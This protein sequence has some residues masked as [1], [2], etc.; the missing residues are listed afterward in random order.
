MSFNIGSQR[1]QKENEREK[2]KLFRKNY[3]IYCDFQ[4]KHFSPKRKFIDIWNIAHFIYIFFCYPKVYD[5]FMANIIVAM[6]QVFC[7]RY[8]R[9]QL[10]VIAKWFPSQV[11]LLILSLSLSF[12]VSR[13]DHNF[14][15]FNSIIYALFSACVGFLIHGICLMFCILIISRRAKACVP[16]NGNDNDI[17]RCI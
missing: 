16:F 17:V 8:I 14:L 9:K 3:D 7:R 4:D 5:L 6:L 2:K 10:F 15:P 12:F 11:F 13:C 1:V